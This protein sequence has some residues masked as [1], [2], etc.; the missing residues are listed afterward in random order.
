MAYQRMRDFLAALE[1]RG[2]LR[3]IARRV[4]PSWEPACLAKWMF[5]ALPDEE[6]FGLFFENV[7]GSDIPLVTA[8][9]GASTETYAAALQAAPDEINAK[10]VR[11][12]LNPVAPRV[13]EDAP[14]QEVI[15]QGDGARLGRLPI[16]VWTPGKDIGPYLTTIVVT[17]DARSG[18]QNLGVY[19][20]R[21]LDDRRLAINLNPGRHGHLCCRSYWEQGKPAPIAWVIAAEPEVH[22][23]TVA[24]LPYGSDEIRVAG[25]LKGEP[26]A[27]ARAKT[28]DLLVPAN[29]EIVIE[30]EIRPGEHEQEG[31]FGEFAGFMGPIGQRP[32][33]RV[34][35]ITHRK[36]PIFYGY[37]SQMPPSESTVIQSLTNAGLILKMLRY[38][39]GEPNV[40]DVYIDLTFGGL[41]AHCVVAL[42]PQYPGHGKRVGRMVADVTPVKRVTVV[43]AD[44]DI[45]DP[46][47]LDWALSSLFNP[48][49]DTVV[50][51]D[52]FY[53]LNMD[54]STRTAED[55]AVPGG[56]LVIDATQKADAGPFSLPPREMMTRALDL[57]REVG[58]PEF[59]IPKRARLRIDRS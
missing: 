45:R 52:V 5:Q 24:N 46:V 18:V 32:M 51:D 10:W 48:A 1:R 8:A 58:L 2:K 9:L 11:A 22:L 55:R 21:V 12:L 53:P 59:R 34:S 23:A 40:R 54:P 35:A 30:A 49:R 41:L 31:P 15:V 13:V 25:G 20:T 39:L 50:I 44:V 19:R 38:D 57:W 37:T 6:R 33:A 14:C 3:R 42:A 16:P 47:H 17:R 56:K 36:D 43:D 4:D 29:A 26:V 28:V 27:L 7:A